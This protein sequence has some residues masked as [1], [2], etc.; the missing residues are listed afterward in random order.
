MKKIFLGMA[1][2]AGALV[3]TA[4]DEET[5]DI[6]GNPNNLIYIRSGAALPTYEVQQTPVGTFGAFVA[7]FTV[8]CTK[9]TGATVSAEIVPDLVEAYND[10]HGTEYLPMPSEA[11][12]LKTPYVTIPAGQ[13]V[14]EEKLQLVANDAALSTLEQS[15]KYLVAVRL[16]NP[17][18]GAVSEDYG[19]TYFAVTTTYKA[20]KEL[21]SIEDVVGTKWTDYTGWT[22][23]CGGVEQDPT[24]IFGG[25]E[26]LEVA[27]TD[28]TTGYTL[29]DAYSGS[30]SLTDSQEVVVDMKQNRKVSAIAACCYF[31]HTAYRNTAY[32][33]NSVKWEVSK[34]GTN[35]IECGTDGSLNVDGFQFVGLYGGAECRYLRLTLDPANKQH[36]QLCALR[37]YGE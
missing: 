3:F 29:K 7:E 19:V 34:D 1:L 2:I 24:L 25:D 36:K 17:T 11:I 22:V 30:I 35:W 20:N 15:G 6:V 23:S 5:Y 37:V 10:E 4:C 21:K 8:Q 28:G 26:M 31:K 32:T 13:L 18:G 27:E 33:F 9:V 14:A 16:A 12:A